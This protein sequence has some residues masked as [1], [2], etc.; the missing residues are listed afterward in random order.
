MIFPPL[1]PN[2][3]SRKA[4]PHCTVDSLDQYKKSEGKEP[5]TR[6]RNPDCPWKRCLSTTCG[7][8]YDRHGRFFHPKEMVSE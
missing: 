4:K 3:G 6:L 8:L 2:C 5:K 7:V 1:C